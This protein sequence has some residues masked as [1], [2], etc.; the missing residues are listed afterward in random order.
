MAKRPSTTG[1]D[2]SATESGDGD[3][4]LSRWARRKRLARSGADPDAE[5]E[6][7]PLP[8]KPPAG[9]APAGADATPAGGEEPAPEPGSE[10]TD[11][12][13]PALDSIDENT[14]MSGFFSEKVSQAVKKAALRKFFHSPVFNVVD[15]LDDYDDDFRNFEALGDIITSDMRSQMDREAERA[16][17]EAAQEAE[18]SQPQEAD[19]APAEEVA[20]GQDAD[21]TVE[22]DHALAR[23]GQEQAGEETGVKVGDETGDETDGQGVGQ[24]ALAAGDADA[25]AITRRPGARRRGPGKLRR[26]GGAGEN[27]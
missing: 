9:S 2:P 10:L 7:S 13:M 1:R 8:R 11:E 26:R 6:T 4:F 19:N 23:D 5:P 16:R 17:Q 18:Q 21:Q 3:P 22:A 27:T 15:G 14:D 12:D 20:A 24:Q 25:G